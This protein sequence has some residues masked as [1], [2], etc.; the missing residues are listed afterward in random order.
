MSTVAES[1]AGPDDLMAVALD[2]TKLTPGVVKR[3]RSDLKDFA[4]FFRERCGEEF[5]RFFGLP[6]EEAALRLLLGMTQ[7]RVNR[8]VKEYK[9]QAPAPWLGERTAKKRVSM[10]RGVFDR[11]RDARLTRLHIDVAPGPR[12]PLKGSSFTVGMWRR[13]LAAAESE[14]REG[15]RPT[16][17]RGLAV[18]RLLHDEVLR[19]AEIVGLDYPGDFDPD[20]PAVRVPDRVKPRGEKGNLCWHETTERT[21]DALSAWLV[22]RGE[23]P[24][25]FLCALGPGPVPHERMRLPHVNDVVTELARRAG[26]GDDVKPTDLR[27]VGKKE[28]ASR[29][30]RREAQEAC[31]LANYHSLA[32]LK[33]SASGIGRDEPAAAAEAP[34]RSWAW[35]DLVVLKGCDDPPVVLDKER[36]PFRTL[37]QFQVIKT[38][39]DAGPAGLSEDDLTEKSGHEDARGIA[40]RLAR[41]DDYWGEVILF[42][43][44]RG[45]GNI[46]IGLKSD[47][48]GYLREQ[49]LKMSF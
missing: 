28:W 34:P 40:R 9:D 29:P 41:G 8:L 16:A 24:G 6:P 15:A 23:E 27:H 49:Q 47:R 36:E 37:A 20:R 12:F 10:L 43:G 3:Y 38:L 48:F 2:V 13:L 45:G 5:A 25:P 32:S 4:R 17:A 39:L 46:R 21:R 30:D 1:S 22:F 31:R 14:C 26:L 33:G 18:I 42:P 11:L 44:K 35:A 7:E 19:P